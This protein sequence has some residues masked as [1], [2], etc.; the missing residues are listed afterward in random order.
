MSTSGCHDGQGLGRVTAV[1]SWCRAL[2]FVLSSATKPC[3]DE[4]NSSVS[5]LPSL[6]PAAGVLP[7]E[8]CRSSARQSSRQLSNRTALS[9]SSQWGHSGRAPF[10]T[11][12]VATMGR[13]KLPPDVFPPLQLST[14]E[15]DAIVNYTDDLVAETLLTGE[16]FI[17]RHRKL[18]PE[19]W[20]YV[21]TQDHLHVYRSRRRKSSSASESPQLLQLSE[22]SSASS[23]SFGASQI[24]ASTSSGSSSHRHDA[25]YLTDGSLLERARPDRVPLV[26]ITGKMEGTVEDAAFGAM[27]DNEARWRLRDAYIG[28]E[29]DDLKILAT[30]EAPSRQ[31][32]F[33]FLGVKWATKAMGTFITQ[34][35]MV[36]VESTGIARDSN[37]EKVAYM[38]KHSYA[39]ERV[40]E[41]SELGVI[42]ARVSSCFIIRPHSDMTVEVFCRAF[43][44]MGGDIMEGVTVNIFKEALLSVGGLVQ[45]A[46]VKK[47]KWQMSAREQEAR[48]HATTL[49]AQTHAP[50]HCAGCHHS[51]SKFGRLVQTGAAC[52]VCR[53]VFCSK[54]T[55]VK[56]IGVDFGNAGSITEKNMNFC[57]ECVDLAVKLPAWGVALET[58]PKGERREVKHSLS[59]SMTKSLR[60]TMSA[61]S[62]G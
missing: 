26:V 38:L 20:K 28:D 18:N 61:S 21:K 35:D 48:E 10:G 31:D 11:W 39:L 30:I 50:T 32:P 40:P 49:A 62:L 46:Y 6:P 15:Q 47:L 3:L 56:R 17:A 54:C 24:K 52:Q 59:S 22:A 19:R 53:R 42:R 29:C 34:R 8:S 44:D 25:D 55:T 1:L 58:M 45:C 9:H 2:V 36:Y 43:N 41:L 12:L 51:L 13:S 5:P 27:A 57:Q 4:C 7:Q 60:K 23:D 37:G 14:A 33:R 16:K